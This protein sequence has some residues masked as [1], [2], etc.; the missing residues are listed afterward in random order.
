MSPWR[1]YKTDMTFVAR[2]LGVFLGTLM[3]LLALPGII[4]PLIG[5][6][7]WAQSLPWVVVGLAVVSALLCALGATLIFMHL[8]TSLYFLP[9]PRWRRHRR[10]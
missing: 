8:R 7:D 4:V 10:R 3:F 5:E 2:H 9:R 1:Q 6:S